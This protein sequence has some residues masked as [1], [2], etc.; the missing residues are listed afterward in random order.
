MRLGSLASAICVGFFAARIAASF[1][2][3]L[4]SELFDRVESFSMAEINQFFDCKPDHPVH[5]R[6]TANQLVVAMGLQALI[7]A[8]IMA[9]WAI[10]KISNKNWQWTTVTAVA[11]AVMLVLISVIVLFAIPRFKR[12]QVLTD[13]INRV[14][15]E[16]LTGVRVVRAYNAEKYQEAK[17][18][19]ANKALTDNNLAA[20]RVMAIMSPGMQSIMSG[21]S[22]AIYW[23]GAFLINA[24]R[25]RKKRSSLATW[26]YS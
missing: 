18:D 8:P 23:I 20:H 12:I 14:T 17:F 10:I 2:R 1:S 15:R 21:M 5:Q 22:L 16:N 26:W 13:N 24:A 3:N 4:R 7:K 9:I 25:S 11:V 6:R 19:K